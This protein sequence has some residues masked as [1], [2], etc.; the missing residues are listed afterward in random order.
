MRTVPSLIALLLLTGTTAV[1]EGKRE[2]TLQKYG[3]YVNPI[4]FRLGSLNVGADVKVADAVT[5]GPYAAYGRSSLDDGHS[6][7]WGVGARTDYYFGGQAFRQGWYLSPFA[8]RYQWRFD[9]EGDADSEFKE[10]TLEMGATNLGGTTGYYIHR[11]DTEI[12]F[13]CRIG[14][15]LMHSSFDGRVQG[16]RKDG[17]FEDSGPA[18]FSGIMPTGDIHIGMLF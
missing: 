17:T 7:Y 11:T 16:E 18:R 13:Y 3:V 2:S 4:L 14:L 9:T 5:V 8:S 15:G 12:H 10:E 1:A 6:H